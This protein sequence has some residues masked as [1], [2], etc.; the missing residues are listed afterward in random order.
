MSLWSHPNVYT[1]EGRSCG[2]GDGKELCDLLVVFDRH[3]LIFS[4]KHCE[5]P[6]GDNIKLAWSR[7]YRRAV[8]KSVQQVLGARNFIRRFPTR[9]FLDKQCQIVFPFALPTGPDVRYHLFAVTRGSHDA[10]RKYFSVW[11]DVSGSGS[12]T[13]DSAL[14]GDE[15]LEHPFA[16][17]Q[18]APGEQ[19]VHVL[20]EMTLEVV[21]RELDTIRDL[22]AYLDKKEALL[23]HPRRKIMS[24]GE[25][26]LVAMYSTRMNDG[27]EH[28]F[29]KFPEDLDG[30]LIEEGFWTDFIHNPKYVAK[31]KADEISYAWDRLIENFTQYGETGLFDK[32]RDL[33]SME[34][35]LRVMASESRLGRR[36]LARYLV[37]ALQ[38]P[39]A[40]GSRFL[41]VGRA[42]QNPEVGY[43]FLMLPQP[44]SMSYER[45]REFRAAMLSACCMVGRLRCPNEPVEKRR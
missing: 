16:I 18:V 12:L 38:R 11:G 26:E 19:Y 10:C 8:K 22:I 20:D 42:V 30:V 45:Y 6:Q 44:E 43:V 36:H 4:D 17:G 1:D 33:G 39:V 13:I 14:S 41:R 35:A 23:T 31:K 15:H 24:S 9:L 40:K 25:E 37:E 21:L 2:K 5:F 34:P 3:V 32:K 29:A 7:W 28:D 27:G